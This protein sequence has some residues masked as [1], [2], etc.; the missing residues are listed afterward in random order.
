M[1]HS[2]N[3]ITIN[4]TRKRQKRKQFILCATLCFL[5]NITPSTNNHYKRGK[6]RE[7]ERGRDVRFASQRKASQCISPFSQ[8]NSLSFLLLF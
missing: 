8:L 6:W 5:V 3:G 2:R 4:Q 1:C 7:V